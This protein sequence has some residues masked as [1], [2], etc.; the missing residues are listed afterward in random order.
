MRPSLFRIREGKKI[1]TRNGVLKL[2]F[3]T[4]TCCA[5]AEKSQICRFPR[6]IAR[7]TPRGRVR[8]NVGADKE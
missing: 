4:E 6:E 1:K 8:T 7:G 5:P 2:A 3:T